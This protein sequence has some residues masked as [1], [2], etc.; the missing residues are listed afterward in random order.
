MKT[1]LVIGLALAWIGGSAGASDKARCDA[2]PFTLNKPAK[3]Q[4]KPVVPALKK[5]P[6]A[7]AKAAAAPS[8][9]KPLADCDKPAA[10][11]PN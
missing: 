8:N 3:P 2:K 9:A 5:P 6:A 10:R 1:Y 4:A 11:K 7:P